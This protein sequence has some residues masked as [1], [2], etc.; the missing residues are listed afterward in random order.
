MS[1]SLLLLQRLTELVANGPT[2]SSLASRLAQACVHLLEVDGVSITLH[3]ATQNRLT[4]AV[5][6]PAS[7]ELERLQDV[8]G[9]GPCWDA[10]LAG[11]PQTTTLSQGDERRWPQFVPAAREH[12]GARTVIGLPMSPHGTP[13]GVLSAHTRDGTQLPVDFDAGLFLADIVA[14]MLLNDPRRPHLDDQAG[15]WSG[16][17]R[18][19]QATGMITA[20]LQLTL[21]DALAVLRAHAYAHDSSLCTIAEQVLRGTLTFGKDTDS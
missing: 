20:Q 3:A 16:R 4:L 11:S 9:Q 1:D 17:D 18:V 19:H 8:L 10:E 6:D 12:V 13:V 14:A 15:P 2:G 5:T 21:Q 7:A